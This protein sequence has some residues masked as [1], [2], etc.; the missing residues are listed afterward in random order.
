MHALPEV[1]FLSG[2]GANA[3]TFSLLNLS[4]CKPVF[5]PWMPVLAGDT[6]RSYALRLFDTHIQNEQACIAGLSFGGMLTTEMALAHPHTRC[7]LLSTNKTSSEFPWWLKTGRVLPMYRARTKNTG[8][9]RFTKAGLRWFLG[10]KD[11]QVEALVQ[12]IA[13]ET[14]PLLTIRF[15]D[16]I[17]GWKNK[18]VPQNIFQVH[19]SAD[20]LLP[21]SLVKNAHVVIP[22]GT[23]IAIMND[24][25]VVGRLMQ[26]FFTGGHMPANPSF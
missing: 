13:A 16:L 4:W 6:L 18:L 25:D 26:D 15:I 8:T 2:L 14:D 12:S 21:A 17:M 10:P 20:R 9:D 22:H 1:Y 7:F 5:V 24:A 19:G 3:R 23:H 11:A